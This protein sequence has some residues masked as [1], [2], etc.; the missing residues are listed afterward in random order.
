MTTADTSSRETSA[1]QSYQLFT[2]PNREEAF[3]AQFDSLASAGG[4]LC[5]RPGEEIHVQGDTADR[6]FRLVE[7]VARTYRVLSDGSRQISDFHFPGDIIGLEAGPTYRTGAEALTDVKLVAVRRSVL[8]F[9]ANRDAEF[10]AGLC[11]VVTRLHRL[12]EEHASILRRPRALD[13]VAAFLLSLQA[14]MGGSMSIPLDMT[15]QEIGDHLGLALHTVSRAF[16]ELQSLGFI[17]LMGARRVSIQRVDE[18]L[19]KC[20]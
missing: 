11:R 6:V 2:P 1:W 8:D 13:R 12:S 7:G 19:A 10:G 20:A 4:A 16:T 18:M 14:R 3:E 9:K 17:K 15:R 5:R